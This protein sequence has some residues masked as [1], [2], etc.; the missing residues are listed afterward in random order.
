VG[1]WFTEYE[2]RLANGE[3]LFLLINGGADIYLEYGFENAIFQSYK[4]PDG[5]SIN[6]EIYQ[7]KSPEG[8][9]GIYTFKSSTTGKPV[10]AGNDGWM[11][12]Y[13]LNFWKDNVLV[14]LIGLDTELLTLAGLEKLA[15]SIDQKIIATQRYPDILDLL[16]QENLKPNGITYLKGNLA[17]YN[18]YLFDSRNVFGFK[19][20]VRGDYGSYNL[21]ILTYSDPEECLK[22]FDSAKKELT[23]N[24]LFH[25]ISEENQY[26][27]LKDREDKQVVMKRIKHT[28]VIWI[29]E[30]GMEY[31]QFF[32]SFM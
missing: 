24:G 19:E 1:E 25:D 17:L 31:E 27:Y 26:L 15:S 23:G 14:T 21:F 32:S 2:P 30:E 4:M 10:K 16:P 5:G 28:L 29:G 11:E 13:Y 6:L 3:E 18:Q 22:W 20:A 8:A 9:Y 7:M 12:E